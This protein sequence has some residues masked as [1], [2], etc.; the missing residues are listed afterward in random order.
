MNLISELLGWKSSLLPLALSVYKDKIRCSDFLCVSVCMS[1][2]PPWLVVKAERVCVTCLGWWSR[3]GSH[4][5][6]YGVVSALFNWRWTGPNA[7]RAL[8]PDL[9]GL[10]SAIHSALSLLRPHQSR[11][12]LLTE[13]ADQYLL[14]GLRERQQF[15]NMFSWSLTHR[16]PLPMAAEGAMG[17]FGAGQTGCMIGGPP[18]TTAWA[19]VPLIRCA[20]MWKSLHVCL[21]CSCCPTQIGSLHIP[22]LFNDTAALCKWLL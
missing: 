16:A 8:L 6:L 13:M 22:H 18:Q 11:L 5:L 20:A 14:C 10:I 1:V 7:T 19:F 15:F 4:G 9:I 17:A 21:G 2:L 3:G 12:C